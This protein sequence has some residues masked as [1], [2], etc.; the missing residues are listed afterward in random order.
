M[1]GMERRDGP[2]ALDLVHMAACLN[3]P[4]A[5]KSDAWSIAEKKDALRL[6]QAD[7]L[8]RDV[9]ALPRS[10]SDIRVPG[11]WKQESDAL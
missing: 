6:R 11:A 9:G 10:E 3:Q 4:F 8:A 5:E 7:L 1:A 2:H